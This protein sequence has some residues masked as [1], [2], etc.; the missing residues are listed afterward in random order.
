M[1]SSSFG[2]FINHIFLRYDIIFDL[3]T[4]FQFLGQLENAN[5]GVHESRK[6]KQRLKI[7]EGDE[8][9]ATSMVTPPA[10]SNHHIQSSPL[11]NITNCKFFR[12]FLLLLIIH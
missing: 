9:R 4:L 7:I 3:V 12:V 6:R 5:Y 11:M 2:K 8:R 10:S 1:T